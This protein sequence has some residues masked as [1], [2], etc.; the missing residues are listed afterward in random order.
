MNLS[1]GFSAILSIKN[2]FPD[3][4]VCPHSCDRLIVMMHSLS[5]SGL[6]GMFFEGVYR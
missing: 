4:M 3:E 6:L 5:K 2:K 1:V